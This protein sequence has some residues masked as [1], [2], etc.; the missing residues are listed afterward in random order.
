MDAKGI[1]TLLI[2]QLKELPDYRG[3]GGGGKRNH[4]RFGAR[5]ADGSKY[6]I[7]VEK[8]DDHA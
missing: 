2:K 5:F 7:T 3:G 1:M 6:V 4:V 8:Q